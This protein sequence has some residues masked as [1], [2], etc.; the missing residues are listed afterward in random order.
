MKVRFDLGGIPIQKGKHVVRDIVGV[1]VSFRGISQNRL[2]TVVCAQNDEALI[3][4]DN[5]IAWDRALA[6]LVKGL[7]DIGDARLLGGPGWLCVSACQEMRGNG[8]GRQR[9][10]RLGDAVSHP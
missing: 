7:P 1:E 2:D 10:H 8:F 9:I 4:V 3:Q 5:V 6:V